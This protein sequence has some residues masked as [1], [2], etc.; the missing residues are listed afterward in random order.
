MDSKYCLT[1]VNDVEN[2]HPAPS[3]I[4]KEEFYGDSLSNTCY[5]CKSP[6]LG[7]TERV[8]KC[9][10]CVEGYLYQE[11]NVCLECEPKCARC[12]NTIDEC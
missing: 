1:C 6:C 5:I 8:D 7:C 4:C 11:P 10:S 12:I 9:V 2:R 3:C